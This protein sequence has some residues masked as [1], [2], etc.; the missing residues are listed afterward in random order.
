MFGIQSRGRGVSHSYKEEF[1][2]PPNKKGIQMEVVCK[3]D[4][5]LV[6]FPIPMFCLPIV[7]K[8]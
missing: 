5:S 3:F 7:Y 1:F 2:L 6:L 8:I 4:E